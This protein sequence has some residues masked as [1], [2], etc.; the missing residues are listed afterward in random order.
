MGVVE[1]VAEPRT[2]IQV[3]VVGVVQPA[4]A[5]AKPRLLPDQFEHVRP[6]GH[7]TR[8]CRRPHAQPGEDA[9]MRTGREQHRQ[10]HRRNQVGRHDRRQ[11]P[12]RGALPVQAPDPGQAQDQQE[13]K[14]AGARM[15]QRVS[16]RQQGGGQDHAQGP[17]EPG[18]VAS[19]PEQG[20]QRDAGQAR[21]QIALAKVA[22]GLPEVGLADPWCQAASHARVL[23]PAEKRA[24]QPG[25]QPGPGHQARIGRT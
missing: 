7:A 18:V 4:P 6:Q 15:R 9:G 25:Q 5:P 1:D 11:R 24:D 20:A 19:Q 14:Q 2:L 8:T 10:A 13:F 16:S 23:Q 17:T 22:K 12:A 21:V 3:H